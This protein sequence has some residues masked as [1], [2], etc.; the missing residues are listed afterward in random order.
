MPDG[1]NPGPGGPRCE[2]RI[3]VPPGLS[4]REPAAASQPGAVV[5]VVEF[6]GD[7]ALAEGP[8]QSDAAAP[9]PSSLATG[10]RPVGATTEAPHVHERWG[11]SRKLELSYCING[12]PGDDAENE[13]AYHKMIRALSATM[14]EWERASGVNFVHVPEDD[15]PDVDPFVIMQGDELVARAD[16]VAGTS[17]YFGVISALEAPQGLTNTLPQTWN[18]PV[19]E[20]VGGNLVRTILLQN[21][22]IGDSA[23]SNCSWCFDTS[24]DT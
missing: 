15:Q 13:A 12:M 5:R 19:L 22:P 21:G 4:S 11:E 10:P 16:C 1:S 9:I 3:A 2:Q 8:S 14:A 23:M 24:S 20:P 18:D 7:D 17:A 6:L